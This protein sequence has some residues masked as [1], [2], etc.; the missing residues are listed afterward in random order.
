[1]ISSRAWHEHGN[2]NADHSPE[3]ENANSCGDGPVADLTESMLCSCRWDISLKL[4]M[5]SSVLYSTLIIE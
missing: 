2:A 1:M 3:T 4:G 5:E